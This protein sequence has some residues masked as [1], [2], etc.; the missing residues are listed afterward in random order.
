MNKDFLIL[1][2]FLALS[3][4]MAVNSWS[5]R[6]WRW[7]HKRMWMGKPYVRPPFFVGED[8]DLDDDA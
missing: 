5:M 7:G 8:T 3:V 1:A 2:L 4:S 6:G